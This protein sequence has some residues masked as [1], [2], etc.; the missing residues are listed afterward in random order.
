MA[1]ARIVLALSALPFLGI[2]LAFLVDPA[3]TG[4]NVGLELTNVTA[5]ND[6]RAVYGGMQIGFAGFLVLASRHAS[7]TVPG[8]VAQV[9]TFGGLFAAR[10]LSWAIDG[11]PDTLGF[12]LHGAEALGLTLG[13][14]ALA[15]ARRAATS[16]TA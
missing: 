1:F 13:V 3:A 8:L 10:V 2:G 14:L 11:W 6:L 7:W 9:A 15:R 12:A 16:A 4:R 5:H